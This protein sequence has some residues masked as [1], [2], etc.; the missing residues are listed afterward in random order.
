M[1]DYKIDECR[2]CGSNKLFEFL[3][4]NSMPIPNGFVKKEDLNKYEERYPLGVCVCENCWL[5]QLT[6]VV[7]AE[8]MFKNYLYIPSTSET[9]LIHFKT[10]ADETIKKYKMTDKDMVIDIGS[11]DGTLLSYFKEKGIKI[12]GIDPASNLVK[13]ANMNGIET[14]DDF[15]SKKLA[16]KVVTDKGQAKVITATNVVAH[17]NDLHDLIAGVEKLLTKD[18]V[19]IMEFPYFVDLLSKNEFDTIYHEHLSYFSLI[20]LIELFKRHNME[21][22]DLKRTPVHGGSIII[23]SAKKDNYKVSSIVKEYIEEEKLKKLNDKIAYID[24]SRRVWVIKRDLMSM[25]R[26]L[27]RQG[28]KVVGYGA[29]AKGNV[30]LNY[31]EINTKLIEYIVDSTSYKQGLYTPGTHIPVFPESKLL[32][33][34]PD[35]VLLLAWNFADEILRKQRTY[36]EKGG[37]FIITI[38]YLRLE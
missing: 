37:Q 17:I 21:I 30:M 20:P 24:F 28:K 36:R 2:I 7:P 29:A 5:V 34:Q 4:L 23:T 11:N 14:I 15:F 13:I 18:G 1:Y 12:L 32:E 9:M 22:I 19:F 33:D 6:H 26:K 16:E 27:K 3:D 35:F 10:L 25:L 38:P 31:C 8:I